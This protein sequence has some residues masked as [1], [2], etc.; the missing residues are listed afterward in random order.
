LGRFVALEP[1]GLQ[2]DEALFEASR[3]PETLRPEHRSLEVGWTWLARAVW[4]TGVNVEAKL[5]MLEHAF[6]RMGC[7]RV[8]FKTDARNA[9]S[10]AALAA[11]PAAFEGILPTHGDAVRRARLGLLQRDR[12]R[13]ARGPR[14]A[15]APTGRKGGRGV[16]S[17]DCHVV[18][19]R[20]QRIMEIEQTSTRTVYQNRSMRVREDEIERP[21]GSHGIFS[22]VE[23]PDFALIVPC[24][25][26]SLHL[27]D[28]FRYSVRA[29]S[30]TPRPSR[31][32]RCCSPIG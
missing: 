17:H 16:H 8:E 28:Q 5:L 29:R 6:E 23:K 3:D 25:D 26:G 12:R 27:V 4:E 22:V 24:E 9:R 11:L 18:T 15:R 7:Q 13:V 20:N 21:D 30:G 31:P 19:A 32:M 2:H 10:R 1:L 14:A